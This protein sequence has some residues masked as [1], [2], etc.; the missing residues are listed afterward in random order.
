MEDVLDLYEAAYDPAY[1]VVCFDESPKQLIAE[2]REPI[3]VQPG[4]PAREDTEYVRMGV[5]DLMMICEPKR[6]WREVLIT[7]RRTKIDFAH[8]MKHVV[9]CYP[10]AAVIRVVLDNLNTHK[11]A[12]LYEAFAP[13]EARAIAR[14]LEFHYTPK[15]GSW[16]NIAEIE[17]AVLSNM[18]LSQRI[19]DEQTLRREVEANVR[20]RNAKAAPVK[21]RFTT[22]DARRKLARMYPRVSA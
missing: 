5:R 2:M 7:E 3:P 15:H 6:G 16:L 11:P 9:S 12:S 13:E 22:Q 20:E 19:P 18:C 14:R 10:E 21:W 17:L 1:P 8:C 4:S